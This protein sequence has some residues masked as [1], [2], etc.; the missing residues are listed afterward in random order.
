[1]GLFGSVDVGFFSNYVQDHERAKQ[2]QQHPNDGHEASPRTHKDFE[3]WVVLVEYSILQQLSMVPQQV[4]MIRY[5]TG[6][7]FRPP[8][9]L[10]RHHQRM[11]IDSLN[12]FTYRVVTI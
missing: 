10:H 3:N 6:I 11:K 7:E 2:D 1:M 4:Y 9:R 12:E 5:Y 8:R